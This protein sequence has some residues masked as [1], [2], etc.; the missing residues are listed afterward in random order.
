MPRNAPTLHQPPYRDA[1][2]APIVFR[3]E[4]MPAQA[5]YPT[6]RHAWGEFVYAFSGVMEVELAEEHYLAPP[7]F[8][9]WLPPGVE[10]RGLNR[11]ETLF[12]S[13]YVSAELC[14]ALPVTTC[15]LAVSP[16]AR[17]VLEHLRAEPPALP[18]SPDAQRLLQVLVD[19][20]A[21]ARCVGSYLPRSDDPV[22]GA[23]LQALQAHP[24]DSRALAKLAAQHHSTERTL[25][26]R[27]QRDLGMTFAEWRQ[28]LRVVAALPRLEAGEKVETIA[29]D[30]GYASASAFIAMFHRMTGVTPDEQR[31]GRLTA[32]SARAADR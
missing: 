2:P 9:I 32:S 18:H 27:C 1:L 10:H 3:A 14:A 4:Q 28:R 12:S 19:Q 16:L 21:H 13:L 8:G 29:L 24:G 26:R 6:H 17:A 23:L 5:T 20:L 30:L 11:R 7:Q 31:T 15:A 22:L 25:S